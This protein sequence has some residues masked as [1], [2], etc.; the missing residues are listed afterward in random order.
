MR[1]SPH[2]VLHLAHPRPVPWS[3]IINPI[4]RSLNLSLVPY[5]EWVTRLQK[6]G[7]DLDAQRE[8]DSMKTNPALRIL[9]FFE[10][11][12]EAEEMGRGEGGREAM[13][14]PELSL[15]KA[16]EVAPAL[17]EKSLPRLGEKDALSWLA[18]W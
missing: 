4:A 12:M 11:A 18:Y 15:K 2:P 9:D 14:M 8:V 17:N 13:G 16:V 6:S 5:A 7:A 3:T 1:N 10:R